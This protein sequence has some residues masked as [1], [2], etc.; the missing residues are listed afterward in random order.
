MNTREYLS[1]KRSFYLYLTLATFFISIVILF[2]SEPLGLNP[3]FIYVAI[4]GL[5]ASFIIPLL[6]RWLVRCP[7]C[8][9]RIS[10][11]FLGG[12][13]QFDRLTC[14][15]FCGNDIDRKI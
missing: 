1:K 7:K 15:P 2:I 9:E 4:C 3:F 10:F 13:K 5:I 8:S 12:T 14:C 6:P 11:M